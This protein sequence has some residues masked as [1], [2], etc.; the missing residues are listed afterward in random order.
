MKLRDKINNIKKAETET[1]I[2]IYNLKVIGQNGRIIII[3]AFSLKLLKLIIN[4]DNFK[5]WKIS[6]ETKALNFTAWDFFVVSLY[7]IS[8]VL[9]WLIVIT[10]QKYIPNS[11]YVKPVTN[12]KAQTRKKG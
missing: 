11:I 8:L 10:A 1:P 5:I 9:C 4:I 12:H 2:G 3:G 6:I 7:P